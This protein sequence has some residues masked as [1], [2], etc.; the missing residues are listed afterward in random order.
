M[1]TF[2]YADG[3]WE[4]NLKRRRCI[5]LTKSGTQ[6]SRTTVFT[7]PYCWQHLQSDGHLVIGPTT[8]RGFKFLGLFACGKTFMPGERIIEYV[9]SKIRKKTFRKRYPGKKEVAP[10]AIGLLD[11][12]C[13]RGAGSL[14]NSCGSRKS[15][16]NAK[17]EEVKGGKVYIVATKSIK[18]G[19]EILVDYGEDYW[20]RDSVH[21]KH[22]TTAKGQSYNKLKYTCRADQPKRKTTARRI[23]RSM[24]KRTTRSMKRY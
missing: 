8:L 23:T 2:R 24:K 12:A 16:C 4:C 17:Y 13:V 14:A 22:K 19:Q 3:K 5:G 6:C 21:K 9:G 20:K 18:S 15:R 7:P 1:W 10:Y 11:A